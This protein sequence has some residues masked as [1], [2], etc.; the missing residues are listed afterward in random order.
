MSESRAEARVSTADLRGASGEP[1]ASRETTRWAVVAWASVVL[2]AVLRVRGVGATPLFDDEYHTR[3]SVEEGLSSLIATFDAHGSHAALPLVQN[4][5]IA[6][7]G[8]GVVSMRAVSVAAGVLT[9]ALLFAVGRRLVGDGPAAL[10]TLA[11]AVSPAHLFYSRFGRGYA[12][13]V[14][15]AALLVGVLHRATQAQRRGGPA[16][17]WW[18]AVAVCAGVLPWVHLSGAGFSLAMGVY[19]IA[20]GAA[21]R[22]TAGA[23]SG[24]VV[25]AAAAFGAG[26][27]ICALL[28][29][30]A[31]DGLQEFAGRV[32][33]NATWRPATVSGV[34]L[35]LFGGAIPAVVCGIGAPAS[36]VGSFRRGHRETSGLLAAAL[37]GP[38]AMLAFTRPYGSEY[39]WSRYLLTALPFTLLAV[40]W[41]IHLAVERAAIPA[42]ALV[43]SLASVGFL[44]APVAWGP[45]A[46]GRVSAPA[47]GNTY[48]ALHPVEA[49]DVPHPGTP[50]LYADLARDTGTHRILEAQPLLSRAVLLY[51]N[52]A[53]Q[54]GKDVVFGWFETLPAS[55]G[56]DRYVDLSSAA[57][58]N[59]EI[60]ADVLVVHR[61]LEREVKSYWRFV[62][63]EADRENWGPTERGLWQL[64]RD[65]RVEDHPTAKPQFA[66]EIERLA[67]RRFGVP[68][69][70]DEQVWA[71]RLR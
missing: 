49:F 20:A 63:G 27:L 17:P 64:Y 5:S 70:T 22:S 9:L 61:D 57:A 15:I 56:D 44:V 28:Y 29:S 2:G 26:A 60:E 6:L 40:T 42:T 35:L 21:E 7:L 52:Y 46:F 55:Q 32:A 12:L 69:Y 36:L 51:R 18:S 43:S 59:S 24:G 11:L 45:L 65:S 30:P 62:H 3:Y 53:L 16:W 4:L 10:A 67:R 8:P 48:L 33:N 31:W 66:L 39:A 13:L 71:W 37:L 54:H 14:L 38:L 47:L 19:A 68:D 58:W 41:G 1:R 34:A 23:R 25:P 50:R